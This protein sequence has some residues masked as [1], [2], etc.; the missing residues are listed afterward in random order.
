MK[1]VTS[2]HTGLLRLG[3][4]LP[5]SMLFWQKATQ[6]LGVPELAEQAVQES[7]FPELSEKRARYMIGQLQKRFPF[8]LRQL[9]G[10]A[11]RLESIQNQV[12]CHWI[13]QLTDPLYRNY[14]A[15]FLLACWSRPT[16]TVTVDESAEWV[17]RQ[18]L[19]SAWQPVTVRRMA[20][21]LLSAATD[22]GLCLGSGR[23]ER[24]L[25]LP[26][27]TESDVELLKDILRLAKAEQHLSTYLVSVG[28]SQ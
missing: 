8:E 27:V 2:P 24:E 22:A 17:S 26:P 7:W 6:D 1:E 20:S 10:F 28:R 21:G 11:P 19:C 23:A 3:L 13:L 15:E 16:T 14:T 5:Q 4:A 9:L 12:L 18:R 25:R